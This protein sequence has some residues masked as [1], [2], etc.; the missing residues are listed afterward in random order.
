MAECASL[1]EGAPPP[2]AGAALGAILAVL[3]LQRSNDGSKEAG[4]GVGA[5]PS[6]AAMESSHARDSESPSPSLVTLSAPSPLNQAVSRV[7]L[8]QIDGISSR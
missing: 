5:V 3:E 8:S 4:P 6:T 7:N 1:Y 2:V